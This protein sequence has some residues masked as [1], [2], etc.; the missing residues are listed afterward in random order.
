MRWDSRRLLRIFSRCESSFSAFLLR[1]LIT[2]TA[3]SRV[4]DRMKAIAMP[5]MHTIPKSL[6][7]G[8]SVIRKELNPNTVVIAVRKTATPTV[9]TELVDE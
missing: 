3:G 1:S 2:I 7:G 5:I 6:I 8:M 4:I 9:L